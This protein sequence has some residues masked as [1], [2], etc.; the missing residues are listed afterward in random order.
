MERS[1]GRPYFSLQKLVRLVNEGDGWPG[2]KAALFGTY[3]LGIRTLITDLPE[4]FSR[5]NHN[6]DVLILHGDMTLS[7]CGRKGKGAQLPPRPTQMP[8]QA[9]TEGGDCAVRENWGQEV[10]PN[11]EAETMGT[12][13]LESTNEE[14]WCDPEK[15]QVGRS[16]RKESQ[17]DSY[18]LSKKGLQQTNHLEQRER[19]E[20]SGMGDRACGWSVT[21]PATVQVEK[22]LTGR[23]G[24]HHP[25]FGLIF[26]LDGSLVVYVST[27][28]LGTNVAVDA[29]WCQLFP[30]QT[31]N[32]SLSSEC[33][34]VTEDVNKEDAGKE[35]LRH[36]EFVWAGD[37]GSTLEDFLQQEG[38]LL[39]QRASGASVDP[40]VA[41]RILR[42]TPG[43]WLKEK[44]GIDSLLDAV[45]FTGACV[46]LIPTVPT[47][48]D[49][50]M[51]D[52]G[53]GNGESAE[54]VPTRY[55]QLR[56]KLVLERRKGE[57]GPLGRLDRVL[58]Q[59]TSIGMGVDALFMELLMMS[60]MPDSEDWGKEEEAH[61]L[62]S[63]SVVWPSMQY[64]E[65]CAQAL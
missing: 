31:R 19:L 22:V 54:A 1:D 59:P 47:K 40:K 56:L 26:L 7:R 34:Q 48:Q 42:N 57:A 28:N 58:L 9:V 50:T 53:M 25:K 33:R 38:K 5:N 32:S 49:L 20:K 4:I 35:T 10:Q 52:D 44:L 24:V 30:P 65:T 43:V 3:S 41:T 62:D 16:I 14:N 45:D 60:Y 2:I 13:C 17:G 39:T 23:R 27:G 29:T 55:G 37:F 36:E 21:I 6:I 11:V 12:F 51:A 63:M 61:R 18:V 8:V 64:M 46:D 15:G